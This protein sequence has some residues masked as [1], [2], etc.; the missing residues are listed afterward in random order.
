MGRRTVGQMTFDHQDLTGTERVLWSKGVARQCDTAGPAGYWSAPTESVR[1][2]AFFAEH[3]AHASGL[4]WVRLG[5]A[6]RKG[7]LNDLDAFVEGALPRITA[8]FTLLTTDGDASVPGD[9]RPATVEA[10]RASPHLISW[11]S[12]NVDGSGAPFIQPFPI[13]LDLHTPRPFLSPRRLLIHLQSLVAT[14]APLV[15]RTPK[16]YCDLNLGMHSSIRRR[17]VSRLWNCPHVVMPRRR[18]SQ[19]ATWHAYSQFPFVLSLA[20]NGLDCHRT[21]EALYLGAAV[22][23]LRSPLDALYEGLPVIILDDIEEIEATPN[24]SNWMHRVSLVSSAAD[25]WRKLDLLR[26]VIRIRQDGARRSVRV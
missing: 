9:I 19:L 2:P 5:T 4:V 16:V 24:L 7:E 20:G 13:G 26:W 10:L 22:I 6:S 8:P 11:H 15:N 18:M 25:V 23:T 17:S 1:D 21:W 12:Q 3:F 14:A